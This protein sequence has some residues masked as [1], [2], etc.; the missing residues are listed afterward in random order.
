MDA[1][2]TYILDLVGAALDVLIDKESGILDCANHGSI[3]WA[4]SLGRLRTLTDFP[5]AE[6]PR[7]LECSCSSA[8]HSEDR[9]SMLRT[10][11]LNSD[12]LPARYERLKLLYQVSNVIHSTLDARQALEL[13]LREAVQLMRA[14]SGSIVLLNPTTNFLEIE[15]AHGLPENATSLK[16]RMGEGVT[17]WVARQGKAARVGNVT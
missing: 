1:S 5:L 10:V 13:I 3:T 11:D 8:C 12:E 9:I 16:L 14:S 7:L 4:D 17:G 6:C 15:A 2:P